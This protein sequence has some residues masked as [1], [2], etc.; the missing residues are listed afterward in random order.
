[1]LQARQQAHH[2]EKIGM[3]D[4]VG[5]LTR[6]RNVRNGIVDL[7]IGAQDVGHGIML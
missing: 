3:I 5:I 4:V 2:P 6:G 1:M 7:T